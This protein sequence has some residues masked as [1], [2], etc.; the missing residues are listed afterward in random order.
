VTPWRAN[1][2]ISAATG[3]RQPKSTMV[4]AQSKITRS[5]APKVPA[6]SVTRCSPEK[7]RHH[8]FAEREAGRG[9][10]PVVTITSRTPGAGV[11]MTTVRSGAEA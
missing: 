4:P 1:A 9:P 2:S 11:S 3:A 8:L 6:L 10:A 5:K 7:I